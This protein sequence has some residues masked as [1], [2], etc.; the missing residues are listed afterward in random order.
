MNLKYKHGDLI[1]AAQAG[2]VNCIAHCANCFNTMKSGIAPQIVKAFPKAGEVDQATI[3]GD[4][5]KLGSYTLA[6]HMLDSWHGVGIYNLYGQFH[7]GARR[8]G[9]RD[10]DYNA[11]Y[12][13]LEAMAKDIATR[14]GDVKVGLPLLG[15]ELAG[16]DWAIIEVMIKQTLVKAGIDVTIYVRE[17]EKMPTWVKNYEQ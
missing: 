3:S 8:Q 9:L 12:D 7:W 14:S 17:I 1:K 5:N 2:E 11:I 10:L 6:V 4:H 13:A 16:G 15:S